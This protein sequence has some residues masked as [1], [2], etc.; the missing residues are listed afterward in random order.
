V[1]AEQLV[2]APLAEC[3]TRFGP[4]RIVRPLPA[5]QR[6]AEAIAGSLVATVEVRRSAGADHLDD[7]RR[8]PRFLGRGSVGRPHILRASVLRENQDGD[9]DEALIEGYAVAQELL[10]RL[11]TVGEASQNC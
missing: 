8:Y 3:G 10:G 5:H 1:E 9:L 4:E 11:D 2:Y 7:G 6:R